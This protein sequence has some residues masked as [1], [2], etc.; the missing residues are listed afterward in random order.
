MFGIAIKMAT[1]S[2]HFQYPAPFLR[3]TYLY[4]KVAKFSRHVK[5]ALKPA[6]ARINVTN[7]RFSILTITNVF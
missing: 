5:M 4:S 6:S 7:D 2:G 3:Q 1:F